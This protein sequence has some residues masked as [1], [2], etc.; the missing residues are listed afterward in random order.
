MNESNY[1]SY[2]NYTSQGTTIN[3]LNPK[4]LDYNLVNDENI[5]NTRKIFL[6]QNTRLQN[7]YTTR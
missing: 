4:E 6:K 2:N 1:T 5:L 7:K 3:S